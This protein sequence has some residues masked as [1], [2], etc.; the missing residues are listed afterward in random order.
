VLRI[1]IGAYVGFCLFIF[2]WQSRYVY[3]PGRHIDNTPDSISLEFENVSVQTQDGE[4]ITGWYVPAGKS[5]S[6]AKKSH[7]V[8][9]CHGNGG[10]IG[11]RV[12]TVKTLHDMGFN[13]LMFDY[14]GYG[15]STGKPSEQGTYYDALACW[16]Y[17]KTE[18]KAEAQDV[19]VFGQSLGGAIASWLAEQVHPGAL[20]MESTLT[21]AT[22]MAAKMFPY[23]PVRLFCS[24]KYDSLSRIGKIHCPV[25][26][27]HS[28]DDGTVPFEHGQKLFAAANEPKRFI[29]MTGDHNSCGID[30]DSSY[31][32]I[33]AEFLGKYMA[34]IPDH[35]TVPDSKQE[36]KK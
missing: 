2:F 21:S 17:L 10:D 6:E 31:R 7:T 18:K 5:G 26:I 4:T 33:A 36:K 11:D 9:V 3:Y 35:K 20:M 22:A 13:V 25:L 19:I 34:V 28:R 24:F 27:A 32:R 14:R 30:F 29:E 8:L 1:V 15:T 12:D 23:L 16:N